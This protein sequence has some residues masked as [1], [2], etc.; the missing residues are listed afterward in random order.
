MG[1]R[2]IRCA[3]SQEC[4]WQIGVHTPTGEHAPLLLK[5]GLTLNSPTVSEQFNPDVL[6]CAWRR[7]VANK[8]AS[9]VL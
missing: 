8:T 6:E 2:P 4:N 3:K 5:K 1:L 9:A 7:P